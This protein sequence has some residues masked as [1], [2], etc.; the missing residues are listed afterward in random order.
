MTYGLTLEELEIIFGYELA[1]LLAD[2][3]QPD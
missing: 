2:R 1:E 3:T